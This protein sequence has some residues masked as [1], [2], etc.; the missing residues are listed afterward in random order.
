MTLLY[1]ICAFCQVDFPLENYAHFLT[2]QV[3]FTYLSRAARRN[4]LFCLLSAVLCYTVYMSSVFIIGNEYQSK[5]LN[6]FLRRELGLSKRQIAALKF[7]PEGLM[8]NGRRCRTN[9][10]LH[11]WDRL[12]IRLKEGSSEDLVSLSPLACPLDVLYEDAHLLA[13]NKPSSLVFHPAHG[14]YADSL[15]N[16]VAAYAA[17]KG[18]SFSVRPVGRL[19]KDTSGAALFAKSAEAAALL[20]RPGA[21]QKTYYALAEG[22]PDPPEGCVDLPIGMDPHAL[23]KMRVD[24]AGRPAQTY[25]RTVA[26]Y[27]SE[28]APSEDCALLSVRIVHGRTHQIRLHLSSIGHPLAGDP[29]Y[30]NGEKS[31]THAMLHCRSAEIILPFSGKKIRVEAPFPE[32]WEAVLRGIN[33]PA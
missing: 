11:C 30:G 31:R 4:S 20:A 8:L 32:D 5:P 9:A 15:A 14:H 26:V 7:R 19:D 24:A 12:E 25:Y 17:S 1:N 22:I 13:V 23:G 29:L 6:A 28:E 18:E 2:I 21:V 27:R 3:F 33:P 16:Q 10:V